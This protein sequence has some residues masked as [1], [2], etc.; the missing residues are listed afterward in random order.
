MRLTP[1]AS[2]LLCC[3]QHPNREEL[4]HEIKR[5]KTLLEADPS[6]DLYSSTLKELEARLAAITLS[7]R[8]EELL[9]KRFGLLKRRKK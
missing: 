1:T 4:T 3:E 7:P 2:H 5:L 9:L 6:N 8:E